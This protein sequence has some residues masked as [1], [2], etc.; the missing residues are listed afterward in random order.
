MN[1][2]E[3]NPT[4]GPYCSQRRLDHLIEVAQ[5]LR[6]NTDIPG[7][8][9]VWYD[10]YED[11]GKIHFELEGHT[12]TVRQYKNFPVTRDEPIPVDGEKRED[13]AGR[14]RGPICSYPHQLTEFFRKEF[15]TWDWEGKK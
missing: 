8:I 2:I 9:K 14:C 10:A 11:F 12:Y 3:V 15:R 6:D 13:Y 5:Q 1:N 4:L 7:I